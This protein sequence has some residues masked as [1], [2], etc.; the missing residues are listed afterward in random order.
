MRY[1]ILLPVLLAACSLPSR[2]SFMPAPVAANP[3]SIAATKAFAGR[4]PLI[5]IPP[6]TVDFATPVA[7]AVHE[8]RAIK[9]S[10][11]FDVRAVSPVATGPDAAVAK[12]AA[13]SGTAAAVAQA[14]IGDGVAP[15]NVTLTAATSGTDTDIFV[16]VK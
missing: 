4:V 16:Y 1:I 5:T 13:L 12:L 10:A 2:T 7:K 6:G 9:P 3:A 8:A 11:Q 14:I 15:E